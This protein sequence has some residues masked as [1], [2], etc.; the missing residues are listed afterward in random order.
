MLNLQSLVLKFFPREQANG[1]RYPLVDGTREHHFAGLNFEPRKSLKNAA[2]PTTMAPMLVGDRVHA[3][4]GRF[5]E[6][7]CQMDKVELW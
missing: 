6:I 5:L 4:L 3:V 2:S 7:T 1:W